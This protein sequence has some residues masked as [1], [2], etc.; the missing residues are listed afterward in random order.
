MESKNLLHSL[1]HHHCCGDD[2][3]DV[4]GN[5]DITGDIQIN[6]THTH[7]NSKPCDCDPDNKPYDTLKT[8]NKTII[9]AINEIYDMLKSQEE[10]PDPEQDM[11]IY[12]YIPASVHQGLRFDDVTWYMITRPETQ[13]VVCEPKVLDKTLINVPEGA[14]AFVLI[15]NDKFVVTKDNG[16]GGKIPFTGDIDMAANGY[17]LELNGVKYVIYGELMLIDAPLFIYVDEK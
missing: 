6:H 14:M 5:L 13:K 15:P 9:G 8:D 16:I 11:M 1:G 2:N 17:K 7:G 3:I 4:Q 12:G 10:K